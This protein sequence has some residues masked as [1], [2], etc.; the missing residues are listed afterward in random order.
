[1]KQLKQNFHTFKKISVHLQFGMIVY[2]FGNGTKEFE[3]K[4][5][6]YEWQ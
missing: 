5:R 3:M 4:I 1:M 2:G 6:G